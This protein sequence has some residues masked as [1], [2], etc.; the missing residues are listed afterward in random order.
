MVLIRKI[1]PRD[2]PQVK[3]LIRGILDKEFLS[4]RQAYAG[5]DLDDPA[6]YYA[7]P[8]DI[9]L[10]AEKDGAII[11]T[12]AIKEG[13]PDTALLRRI[14]LNKAFRGNG[15]GAKLLQKAL[16]FCFE[17]HYQNVIFR[18]T[19]TMQAALKLCL[20]EGFEETDVAQMDAFKMHVLTKRLKH[21]SGKANGS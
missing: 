6:C 4:E 19:D 16:A 20:K 15:Y 12:V 9:F 3:Q 17:Q 1:C 8:K 13:A 10:V 11:G 14:F 18:G 5:S 7:G 2:T 21:P